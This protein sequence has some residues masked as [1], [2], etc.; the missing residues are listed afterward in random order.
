[1]HLH[2]VLCACHYVIGLNTLFQILA[3]GQTYFAEYVVIE[4]NCTD[5]A[6]VPMNDAMAVSTQSTGLVFHNKNNFLKE[7]NSF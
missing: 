5:D 3:G 2:V 7:K 1:M 6:C 4:A